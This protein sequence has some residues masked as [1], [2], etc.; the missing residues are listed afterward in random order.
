M[1]GAG[2]GATHFPPSLPPSPLKYLPTNLVSSLPLT[3]LILSFLSLSPCP[4]VGLSVHPPHLTLPHAVSSLL[5]TLTQSITPSFPLPCLASIQSLP[6]GTLSIIPPVH[7]LSLSP[8]P[9]S[10]LLL[11]NETQQYSCTAKPVVW[12]PANRQRVVVASV[13]NLVST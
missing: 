7:S 12:T 8:S 6:W 3:G 5:P 13:N 11:S 4:F 1:H 2:D 10:T 9:F